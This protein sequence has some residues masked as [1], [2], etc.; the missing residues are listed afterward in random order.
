MFTYVFS[1]EPAAH[2]LPDVLDHEDEMPPEGSVQENV[3]DH[4]CGRIHHQQEMAAGMELREERMWRRR[5]R[6][7]EDSWPQKCGE[8][9]NGF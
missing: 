2:P 3:Q 8:K 4:V 9:K 5:R 1:A 6:R 7:R